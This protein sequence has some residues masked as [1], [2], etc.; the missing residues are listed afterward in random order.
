M[1]EYRKLR[2][3]LLNEDRAAVR[4][5]S[6]TSDSSLASKEELMGERLCTLVRTDVTVDPSVS[7]LASLGNYRKSPV[8]KLLQ[9]M[10]K[11]AHLHTHG[12]ATGDFRKLV[13]FIK[14]EDQLYLWTGKTNETQVYGELKYF[15]SS[16]DAGWT[17]CNNF[18]DDFLYGLLTMA[19]ITPEAVKAVSSVNPWDEFQTLWIRIRNLSHSIRT[20]KGKA[21]FFWSMLEDQLQSGVTYFEM[22]EIVGKDYFFHE[23]A[24]AAASSEE[25]LQAFQDT[26]TLFRKENPSF[27]GAKVICCGLKFESPENIREQVILTS[28]LMKQFPDSVAGFDLVGE[29][30]SLRPIHDYIEPLLLC[31]D[32]GIPLLLHAGETLKTCMATQMYDAIA[33]GAERMGHGFDLINHP[34]LVRKVKEHNVTVECC[35]I[36]NQVL[37]YAPDLRN[38]N[39][40]AM[41]RHDIRISISSD[42]AGMFHYYDPTFDWTAITIAWDLSLFE[43]KHLARS[44]FSCST[45]SPELVAQA[46]R[47]FDKDWIRFIEG[48]ALSE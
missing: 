33:I 17:S 16:P 1:E 44:S 45:L 18:S 41:L 34:S 46:E 48:S 20:W 6:K 28:Q 38:H 23:Y 35:P 14:S 8:F 32:L 36:S 19:P 24:P 21:S 31:K 37:G 4:H 10:P 47:Q 5:G 42:D 39:G 30:D 7:F 26:V 27:I 43:L 13:K 29:E 9:Q 3:S 25:F 12:I 11:G 40:K 2:N 22:R 15:S